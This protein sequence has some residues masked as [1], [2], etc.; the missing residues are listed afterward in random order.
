[1]TTRAGRAA[2]TLVVAAALVACPDRPIE[3]G[4]GYREL[5][6]LPALHERGAIRILSPRLS[7]SEGLPRHGHLARLE[8]EFAEAFVHAQGLEPIWVWVRGREN[9]IPALL[10]GEGDL[11]AA[12]LTATPARQRQVAF[13]APL[14]LVRERV[15]SRFDSPA[16]ESVADLAGRELVVRHSSSYW[17]TLAALLV[18]NPD[19]IVEAAPEDMDTEEI[20]YR[21]ST[22]AFDATVADD[23]IIRD[24]MAYMPDLVVGPEL[25]GDR[26]IS[27]AF[28]PNNP[29]LIAA[30]SVFAREYNP[31]GGRPDRYT[32]DLP[33]IKERKVLRVLTRNN[34]STYFVYRGIV[35]GFEFDLAREFAKR[36]GLHVQFI[37]VPTRAGLLSWLRQGHGDIVAAGLTATETRSEQEVSFSRPY[38]Y[39]S[40]VL[41]GRPADS[42]L[43]GP[44]DLAGRT[45]AVRRS[46]SYWE[47]VT[48]LRDAGVTVD[49]IPVPEDLE[50][51]EIIDG[52][53]LG[54]YDLTIADSNI[55]DIELTWRDDVTG[56]FSLRDSM[57]HAWA[58]REGDEVLQAAVDDFFSNT[59]RGEF[60]NITHR[61]YF[62][63]S[64][65][66]RR[67]AT[68]R[69]A[70]TGTLSPYDDLFRTY[71]D[72]YRFDWRL[73]ASQSY[74]ESRFDPTAVSFAG[75]VGLMQVM[76]RTGREMGFSALHEPEVS[77]HAGVLY[78]RRVYDRLQDVP[79]PDDRLWFALAAYNA[80]LGH[81][82]DAR[83]LTAEL[84]GDPDIWFGGVADVMP[85]LRKREYYSRARH[86]YCRCLEPVRYVELIRDR[87]RAYVE[88]VE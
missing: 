51:E 48:A 1:M 77:V 64:A 58:V 57:P 85:L 69:S 55:L 68:A 78:L 3:L 61:K 42:A 16:I 59:Y 12:M 8:H 87:Q 23:R 36:Q 10:D 17:E 29:E 52:V 84:S 72:R 50:T 71:A 21:V 38:T 66:V 33:D 75:A 20:L 88:V 7:T 79:N 19:I 4:S 18:E 6:D 13:A 40:E 5:G 15:V 62:G 82:N 80:G 2:F 27:W 37:V 26:P 65:R 81:V 70:R 47:T 63:R 25:T 32:G 9:L 45:I 73:I 14:D 46:S 44:A 41:V 60:Y 34:P 31:E 43:V 54:D 49:L 56:L 83:R 53:A 24:V 74:Q 76:P 35:M 39:V 67:H 28:R 30:A 86:G 11:V 22:G